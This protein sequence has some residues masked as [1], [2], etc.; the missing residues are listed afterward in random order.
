MRKYQGYIFP[1][2]NS[3]G[4]AIDFDKDPTSKR[5]REYEKQRMKQE[6]AE[7]EKGLTAYFC[8]ICGTKCLN[9]AQYKKLTSLP[10]RSTDKSLVVDEALYLRD[11][12]VIKGGKV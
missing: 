1:G 9:I 3:K 11:L 12:R 6:Y 10:K 7:L 8:Q 5:N 2:H 4:L